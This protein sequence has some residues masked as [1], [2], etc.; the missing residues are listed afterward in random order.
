MRKAYSLFRLLILLLLGW[1]VATLSQQGFRIDLPKEEEYKDRLLRSEKTKEGKLGYPSR[2]VQ[3]TVTHYNFTYNAARKLNEVLQ[4][5][6][7]AHRD[8]YS[9]LL[10]FYNFSLQTTRKDSTHLDSVI[11]KASSGIA[12]HDLRNDW[13]DNLYLLWG[14]AY[15]LQEKFDSAFQVFQFINY[16]YAPHEKDGYFKSIGSR[17]GGNRANS[18]ASEEKSGL[19]YKMAVAPPKRNEALLWMIRTQLAQEQLPEAAGLIEMLRNDPVFPKR[20]KTE[21]EELIALSFYQQKRW[22]SAAVHL[23]KALEGT[24]TLNEKARWEFLTG[25]LFE[26]AGNYIAA[27][28]YYSR[29]VPHSADL[30]LEIQA[31]IAAIRANRADLNYANSNVLRLLEMSTK[32][33]YSAYQD[34]IYY[35][36]AQMDLNLGNKS[37]AIE[38]LNQSTKATTNNTL[39]RNKAFLQLAEISYESGSYALAA[40][41]YDSLKTLDS[42]PI[43]PDRLA[44][45][46]RALKSLVSKLAIVENQDS[47]LLLASLPEEERKDAVKKIIKQLRKQEGLQEDPALAVSRP[48]PTILQA[49]SLFGNETEKGE[50]YF[51]N[52]SSR[53]R[54]QAAFIARWGN[55][56]NM[57]NWRRAAS[58]QATLALVQASG[59]DSSGTK[60]NATGS[61]IDFETLYAGLPLTAEKKKAC[62]DSLATALLDAGRILIE[63]IEDC[64]AGLKLLNRINTEFS[65]YEKMDEVL[66]HQHN[67]TW[68]GGNRDKAAVILKEL[69]DRFA[70]SQFTALLNG[71][72]STAAQQQSKKYDS[73]YA[74]IYAL[75]AEG[76]YEEAV[77]L[78]KEAEQTAGESHWT[79][80]LLYIEA[81]YYV[82]Q[83]KDSTAI[84]LLTALQLRYPNSPLYLR[85]ADLLDAISKRARTLEAE[86]PMMAPVIPS[87]TPDTSSQH[88]LSNPYTWEEQTIHLALFVL[89]E[90][91]PVLAAEA[92]RSID[93]YNRSVFNT[94]SFH[95]ELVNLDNQFRVIVISSFENHQE[96]ANY[97]AS[98]KPQSASEVVP[99]LPAGKYFWMPISAANLT[100]LLQRKDLDVY[101]RFLNSRRP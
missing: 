17:R 23:S 71:R 25:Q 20:L 70:Q 14:M 56:P 94:R 31:R 90:V 63:E 96:V 75:F 72:E 51:Y 19:L 55:R 11:Q 57:D 41:Y 65:S 98:I 7:A 87:A 69:N 47:L 97:L 22:D 8:D 68:R 82:Q 38:S 101:Q 45:K 83:K 74:P 32:E 10:P 37:R 52:A 50:W 66:F 48:T 15:Y 95:K 34:I 44:I 2:L 4:N 60:L 77:K 43:D 53:S 12:L 16:Y 24:S 13:N 40:Q 59:K 5:A 29:A 21:L 39:Q 9:T 73:I 86:K 92:M 3:N 76:A 99:W 26:R 100:V 49:P 46:K 18:I 80:Q 64:A 81:V 62:T 89:K 33:K 67:C 79:S 78:K 1:P 27:N 36:A 28:Q 30:I 88:S 35:T 42:L 61:A 54:G 58:M 84:R 6:K 85:A 93:N 91:D